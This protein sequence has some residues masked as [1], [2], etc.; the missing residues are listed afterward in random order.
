MIAA[1]TPA[2][3][4]TF[5]SLDQ[6]IKINADGT[7]HITETAVVD[8]DVM[9]HGI[10]RDLPV[11]YKTDTGNPFS[12]KITVN[13]VTDKNGAPLTY[14]LSRN[15][16]R[17]RIQIGDADKLITGKQEYVISYNVSRALL[18]LLD[19]D[20]LYWNVSSEP[21]G[22]LGWPDAVSASVTLPASVG[23]DS[24]KTKCFTELGQNASEI[25]DISKSASGVTFK[26]SRST[27][28]VIPYQ[29]TVLTIVVGWPKGIVQPP[30]VF[31]N[32]WAWLGDNWII[33]WPFIIFAFLFWRWWKYGRDPLMTKTMVVEYEPYE[34]AAPAELSVLE[35]GQVGMSEV[36]ATIVHLA[37]KG[38]LVIEETEKKNIFGSSHSYIFEL[39]KE[40]AS[41][42]T[43]KDF[44][45]KI[46]DGIFVGKVGERV[47]LSD[48]ENKFYTALPSIKLAMADAVVARGW[49]KGSPARIRGGY[50]GAAASYAIVAFVLLK[51]WTDLNFGPTGYVA[52]F[53]PAILIAIFG[54]FMPSRTVAGNVAY[55]K[56]LGFKEFI[57]KAE[58][59]RAKWQEK[60]NI[61]SDYLP[62]AMIF[63]VADK[64]A[65]VFEGLDKNP[66]NWYRGT[67][68]FVWSP[69][70]FANSMSSAASS[71]SRSLA[72]APSSRGGGGFGG[73]GGGGG[74]FGGGGGG[75]W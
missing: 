7:F 26:S 21:W 24:I 14:A 11:K 20:E 43:L 57:G 68:G 42:Q 12:T 28:K 75:S 67:P 34:G 39:K 72:V 18:F 54:Y 49:Y 2:L 9:K 19:H 70:I 38:C 8:F 31:E 46:L 63:G 50:F 47:K 64:W 71:I 55:M 33:L 61:F 13:S 53:A 32:I 10:F 41:D 56:M 25:C 6:Q 44:E 1:A 59:Y 45:I 66:P 37:V 40:F 36:S 69:L 52:L 30:T 4:S 62:Y 22:D 5:N 3:A 16:D 15:G 65:K 17:L 60:E 51:V 74:G 73:G 29:T 35:K 58:K 27:L 48:L 23:A